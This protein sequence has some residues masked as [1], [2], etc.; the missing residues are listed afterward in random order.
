MT[1][2]GCRHPIFSLGVKPAKV[3]A[4]D[5]LLTKIERRPYHDLCR[6]R[7]TRAV[8]LHNL[9]RDDR[10]NSRSASLRFAVCACLAWA[11]LPDRAVGEDTFYAG[12]TITIVV[13]GG[14][15]Y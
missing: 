5:A 15:A 10:M 1:A 2:P 14:G 7:G 8:L 6:A 4:R 9:R 3:M 11:L 13:D 12:K